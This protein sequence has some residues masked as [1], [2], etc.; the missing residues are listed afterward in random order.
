M[1]RVV[2]AHTHSSTAA[3]AASIIHL[4]DRRAHSIVITIVYRQTCHHLSRARRSV[5]RCRVEATRARVVT[6]YPASC[7]QRAPG[8]TRSL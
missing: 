7:R 4:S 8:H 5:C 1:P 6:L 2:R 3:A